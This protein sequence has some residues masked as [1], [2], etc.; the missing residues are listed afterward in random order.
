MRS[1]TREFKNTDSL[2]INTEL[3]NVLKGKVERLSPIVNSDGF[4]CTIKHE[5]LKKRFFTI[6]SEFNSLALPRPTQF[7]S[8]SK[9]HSFFRNLAIK[10]LKFDTKIEG[11]FDGDLN[12]STFIMFSKENKP[13]RHTNDEE[14]EEIFPKQNEDEILATPLSPSTICANI[15]SNLLAKK[16]IPT[17]ST[18]NLVTSGTLIDHDQIEEQ[19]V[20][21]KEKI[22]NLI[23][24][25]AVIE[26]DLDALYI[27]IPNSIGKEKAPTPE[28]ISRTLSFS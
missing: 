19:M 2:E 5:E 17:H 22:E 23:G 15:Q 7:I 25:M 8:R 26:Q 21:Y 18:S 12:A 4:G 3:Y 13:T 28:N 27:E 24:Q 9:I 10:N 14:F 20:N 6:E 11:C 1:F 16:S